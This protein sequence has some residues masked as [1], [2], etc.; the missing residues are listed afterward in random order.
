MTLL[1]LSVAGPRVGHAQH[2]GM[3][4]TVVGGVVI[5]L[6]MAFS[7]GPSCRSGPQSGWAIGTRLGRS[8]ISGVQFHL[9]L[10]VQGVFPG[11]DCVFGP[12]MP[13]DDGEFVAVGPGE[14]AA[15]FTML[16][17][18]AQ[19]EFAPFGRGSVEPRVL[20]G[21]EWLPAKRMWTPTVGAAL[22]FGTGSTRFRLEVDRV[23]YAIPQV[24]TV[25][26]MQNGV[27]VSSESTET[28][29][30]A[31]AHRLR[32]GISFHPF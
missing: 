12:I 11:P 21:V 8:V 18:V 23:W 9:G 1:M 16:P 20:G 22:V 5:G 19:L 28:T 32:F 15:G 25:F 27:V 2:G 10:G 13:H 4:A 30:H 7:S 31:R 29:I 6:P 3:E 14:H 26:T 24:T 17:V